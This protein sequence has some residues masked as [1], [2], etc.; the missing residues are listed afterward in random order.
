METFIPIYAPVPCTMSFTC[1]VS[2][3]YDAR[4]IYIFQCFLCISSSVPKP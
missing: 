4:A 3:R 2:H 1:S